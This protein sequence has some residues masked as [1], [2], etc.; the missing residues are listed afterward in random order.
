MTTER[1]TL[2]VHC[3]FCG[4]S[5][6]DVKQMIAGPNSVYICNECVVLSMEIVEEANKE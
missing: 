1:E 6:K 2:V 3:S 4:K 5:S